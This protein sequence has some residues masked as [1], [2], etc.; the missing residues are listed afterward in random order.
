[1]NTMFTLATLA[2]ERDWDGPPLFLFP[3]VWIAAIALIWYFAGRRWRGG[4]GTGQA[5]LAERYARGEI[6]EAEYERR[7]EY[8]R[9]HK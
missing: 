5:V 9:S 1:M 7:R 8:L 3:L 4:R 6:D 2:H